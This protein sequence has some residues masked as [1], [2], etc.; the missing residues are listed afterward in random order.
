MSCIEIKDITKHYGRVCALNHVNLK[1]EQNKIYGLLG[2][3]G[4][5]KSTLLNLIT[6]RI[7]ADNG[8]I[9]VD[10]EPIIGNDKAL[11]KI[12]LMNDKNLYPE[13]MKIKAVFKWTKSF[14]PDFDMEYANKLAERFELNLNR[15]VN[16]L[17]T[18][19]SSIFKLIIALSVNTPYIFLD[20]PVLGLDANHR[21]L[22]YR[23]LIEKY[24]EKPSAIIIS[25]HLIEEIANVI[26]DIIIIKDGSIIK[27][28]S[29]QELLS[30]GYT[31][32]GSSGA[33]DAYIAGKSVLGIDT[34]GGLKTAYIL[35]TAAHPLPEQL[36]ISKLD[37]Q[38][39]FIQLTNS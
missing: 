27:N 12:Y 35:G 25:T 4:A 32:S 26:E 34:L 30:K 1:F 21:D 7:F 9:F 20:E 31:V 8:E 3:N 39:L 6:D 16:S 36:E 18:G 5:G 23:I 29:C 10:G 37:L 19:Y 17:S 28:E 22:F 38:K 14:Y 2:R 33:V 11:G 13:K 24:S 15:T